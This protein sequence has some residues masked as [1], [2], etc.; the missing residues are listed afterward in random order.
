MYRRLLLVIAIVFSVVNF[1]GAS[2]PTEGKLLILVSP[3]HAYIYIDGKP[4]GDSSRLMRLP[5]GNHTIAA[6]NYG[7]KSESREV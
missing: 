6:Y 3:E 7:Y 1:L 2:E 5:V 4:V